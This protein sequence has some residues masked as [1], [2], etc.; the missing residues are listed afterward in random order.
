MY[1]LNQDKCMNEFKL[2]ETKQS[3]YKNVSS[4][5]LHKLCVF[6]LFKNQSFNKSK[7]VK[8]ILLED[9]KYFE[10]LTRYWI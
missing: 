6:K 1:A 10:G 2:N 8:L 9:S 4:K 3:Y 7:Y 5:Y